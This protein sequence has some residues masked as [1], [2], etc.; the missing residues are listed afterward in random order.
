MQEP[1]AERSP[2][3]RSSRFIPPDFCPWATSAHEHLMQEFQKHEG[4][5][6][7]MTPDRRV[8]LM[9]ELIQWNFNRAVKLAIAT[10]KGQASAGSVRA[11][12]IYSLSNSQAEQKPNYDASLTE[13]EKYL[14]GIV[15][16]ELIQYGRLKMETLTQTEDDSVQKAEQKHAGAEDILGSGAKLFEEMETIDM[17]LESANYT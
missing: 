11:E 17:L 2:K 3:P 10:Q 5:N 4:G 15:S 16:A 6:Q 1:Q 14:A 12:E 9:F 13:A 8:G 7:L